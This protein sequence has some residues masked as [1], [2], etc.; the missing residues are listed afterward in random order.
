VKLGESPT[1]FLSTIH[2][3]ITSIGVLNGIVARPRSQHRS[4]SGSKAS[5]SQNPS[6]ITVPPAWSW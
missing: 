3:G 4:R 6:P 5:V 2:I 1:R